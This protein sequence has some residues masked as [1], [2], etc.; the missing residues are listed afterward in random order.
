MPLAVTHVLIALIV[1]DII[2]DYIIK[3][4]RKFPLHYVLIA[5]IAGML[6]DIDILFDWFSTG[7]PIHRLFTHTLILPILFLL[8]ALTTKNTKV[9]FLTKHK[10]RLNVVFYMIALG[11]FIHLI[12]DGLLSGIIFPFFPF[13]TYSFGLDLIG[14]TPWPNLL[15]GIDAILLIAWLIHEEIRHKISDF[16]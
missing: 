11:T 15:A 7:D 2:R 13:S 6:P 4:P 1:A 5:G 3:V 16:I 14:K 9:K 10:L 8:L 12:L